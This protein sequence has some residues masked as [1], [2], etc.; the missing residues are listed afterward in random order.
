M[1]EGKTLIKHHPIIISDDMCFVLHLILLEIHRNKVI[2]L[3][4]NGGVRS[5]GLQLL[6]SPSDNIFG[7]V[8]GW[9]QN[10]TANAFQRAVGLQLLFYTKSLISPPSLP[11]GPAPV[12]VCA[13]HSV[14]CTVCIAQCATTKM[15]ILWNPH[16]NV[17]QLKNQAG[18]K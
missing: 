18:G 11:L 1:T 14:H 10:E 16:P 3:E 9:A 2:R 4:W 17:C 8:S 15:S 12:K 13:L 7:L 5:E 6:I